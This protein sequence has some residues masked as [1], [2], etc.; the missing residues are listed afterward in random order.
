MSAISKGEQP[1]NK[2]GQFV[3]AIQTKRQPPKE[4][5]P[6]Q[7]QLERITLFTS[8]DDI[9]NLRSSLNPFPEKLDDGK[10][11]LIWW[12][13]HA[14]PNPDAYIYYPK[15]EEVFSAR[16]PDTYPIREI[17]AEAATPPP[18]AA[19]PKN[20]TPISVFVTKDLCLRLLNDEG[21]KGKEKIRDFLPFEF[22]KRYLPT[23]N[24]D[25]EVVLDDLGGTF[26]HYKCLLKGALL[27]LE[28]RDWRAA[29]AIARYHHH[30]GFHFYRGRD[31]ELSGDLA[32]NLADI[33]LSV[34][35]VQNRDDKQSMIKGHEDRDTLVRTLT[36]DSETLSRF[37]EF[38]LYTAALKQALVSE[39]IQDHPDAQARILQAFELYEGITSNERMKLAR[40]S[41]R[42]GGVELTFLQ[43][44]KILLEK[45][46]MQT[47][48]IS[49]P[50]K[51]RG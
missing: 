26:D 25:K 28:E 46:G 49:P 9:T 36:V 18:W 20:W 21:V 30:S 37:L 16:V 23:G 40:M 14:I 6:L 7:A 13:S 41:L 48:W 33:A 51:E 17:R 47:D 44:L 39:E 43:L 3:E 38:S 34:T 42:L 50:K 5:G 15:T 32:K 8:V 29:I 12:Q 1:V 10:E 27:A 35:S 2:A 19:N 4:E 24:V 45:E 31:G 11:P 22:L